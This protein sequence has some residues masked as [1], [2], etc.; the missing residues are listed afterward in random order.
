MRISKKQL[1][2]I[3][4]EAILLEQAVPKQRI[5]STDPESQKVYAMKYPAQAV[6]RYAGHDAKGASDPEV[7]SAASSSGVEI[8]AGKRGVGFTVIGNKHSLLEFDKA[9][10]EATKPIRA[11]IESEHGTYDERSDVAWAERTGRIPG[12]GLNDV[13]GKEAL[14][15]DGA[16]AQLKD[17]AAGRGEAGAQ[18]L[19]TAF[20]E[21]WMGKYPVDFKSSAEGMPSIKFAKKISDGP[22]P[23]K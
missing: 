22:W 8:E 7:E 19:A 23:R 3:I 16:K 17:Y 10:R 14:G 12:K 1:R 15:F 9:Y 11:K 6:G 5:L 18:V 20:D 4:K 21:L 13:T 2:Q